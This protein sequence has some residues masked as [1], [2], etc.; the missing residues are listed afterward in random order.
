MPYFEAK[1]CPEDLDERV[2]TVRWLLDRSTEQ[3]SHDVFLWTFLSPHLGLVAHWLGH[4]NDK[5]QDLFK[6]HSAP[7]GDAKRLLTAF[8]RLLRQ[9]MFEL[10][11]GPSNEFVKDTYLYFSFC[12]LD[13]APLT[14][15]QEAASAIGTRR[16]RRAAV[17]RDEAMEQRDKLIY[18]AARDRKTYAQICGL[19]R[20]SFPKDSNQ[21]YLHVTESRICQIASEYAERHGLPKPPPRQN[22]RS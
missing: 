2:E 11:L 8:N 5:L 4:L 13:D 19:V 10:K 7:K 3:G 22:R 14:A 16:P 12:T 15:L 21:G 1:E 9:K 18:E 6:N 17:R 20:K